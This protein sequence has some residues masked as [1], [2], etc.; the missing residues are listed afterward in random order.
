MSEELE[1]KKKE[2][3]GYKERMT[4]KEEKIRQLTEMLHSQNIQKE[5][6]ERELKREVDGAKSTADT[7]QNLTKADELVSIL[8]YVSKL[9]T[10][11]DDANREKHQMMFKSDI[12]SQEIERLQESV[13]KLKS[14]S[15]SCD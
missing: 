4:D 12:A 15:V 13:K 2:F 6:L 10:E 8:I 14:K 7:V 5:E 9:T 11:L 1:T 3:D